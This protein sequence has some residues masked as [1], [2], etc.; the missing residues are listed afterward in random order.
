MENLV[1]WAADIGSIQMEKFGWCRLAGLSSEK[2]GAKIDEFAD[3]IACDL[4]DGLRIAVGFECPLFV[5]VSKES[6]D[7]TKA[8]DGEGNHPWS[9]GAGCGA[10][11]TGLPECVWI[12]ERIREKT[13]VIVQP[14]FNW[15]ELCEGNANLFIWEAMITGSSGVKADEIEPASLEKTVHE[16]DARIAAFTFLEH[17]HDIESKNAVTAE[18]PFSLVGAALLRAGL[19]EKIELLKIPCIV[20]KAHK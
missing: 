15:N 1:V 8:R 16:N 18:N 17:Q 10:L 2:T 5:P 14:T 13:T 3:G 6:E 20:V 12:F 4:N 11:T 7:L 19:S 9:A